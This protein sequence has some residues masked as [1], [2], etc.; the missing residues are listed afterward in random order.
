ME[1][2]RAGAAPKAPHR[3][4]SHCNPSN[5][6]PGA[7]RVSP[8]LEL[9]LL[10]TFCSNQ[11]QGGSAQSKTRGTETWQPVPVGGTCKTGRLVP[12][13]ASIH[14]GALWGL[15]PS[16]IDVGSTRAYCGLNGGDGGIALLCP[17]CSIPTPAASGTAAIAP[18]ALRGWP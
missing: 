12:K 3:T 4:P 15:I 7:R 1:E 17:Q 13:A 5:P 18:A 8:P 10:P 11:K 9:A 6:G 16:S 2:P 14:K